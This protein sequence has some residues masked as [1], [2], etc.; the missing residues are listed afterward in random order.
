MYRIDTLA[1]WKI[2]FQTEL[3]WPNVKL[4]PI[5]GYYDSQVTDTYVQYQQAWRRYLSVFD[6]ILC[7]QQGTDYCFLHA[8]IYDIIPRIPVTLAP[9][10]NSKVP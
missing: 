9:E 3:K 7:R 1:E 2:N 4:H 10:R 6:D 8:G 5:H